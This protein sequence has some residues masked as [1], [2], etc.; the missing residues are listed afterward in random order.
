MKTRTGAEVKNYPT[1][2][3]MITVK[4]ITEINIRVKLALKTTAIIK[5]H[6]ANSP[7]T[8]AI[9]AVEEIIETPVAAHHQNPEEILIR[10]ER[11]RRKGETGADRENGDVIK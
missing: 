4:E 2:K 3:M 9:E 6:P 7:V 1:E 8:T 5:V 10:R 11:G